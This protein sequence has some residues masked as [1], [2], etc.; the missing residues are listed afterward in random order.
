MLPGHDV[1]LVTPEAV[2]LQF[3]TAGL[4]SRLLAYA[5]D[6]LLQLAGL[7]VLFFVVF[8]TAP[9]GSSAL[10]IIL[11]VGSLIL[12]GYH[13]LFETLNRGRS[14]GKMALG[15]RVVTR[16]GGPVRFRHAAIRGLLALIEIYVLSAA[17]AVIAVLATR[18]NQRLGD[19]VAGTLVV[20]E[21]A[22]GGR[23]IEPM[24]FRAPAGFE[25][26]A[27]RLDVARMESRDYEAVR[28]YAARAGSLLPAVRQNIA[29]SLAD[30]L[31]ARLGHVPPPGMSAD[32]YLG[33]VAVAYQRR[34]NAASTGYAAPRPNAATPTAPAP[35][36]DPGPAPTPAA[37]PRRD[38]PLRRPVDRGDKPPGQDFVPP[39]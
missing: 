9:D 21:R 16:E 33:C 10:V 17:I 12:L 32:A 29:Q 7:A 1:R 30:A 5:L 20:R 26:Y 34:S 35:G 36:P 6:S 3:E 4:G 8:A 39:S 18:H 11:S 19:L 22:G 2:V 27:A 25:E 15:L 37:R 31:V 13:P 23:V 24:T 38:R 28:S 14:P